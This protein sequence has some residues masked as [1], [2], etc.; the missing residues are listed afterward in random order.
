MII[1]KISSKANV[2]KRVVLYL[3][4]VIELPFIAINRALI[5]E[6]REDNIVWNK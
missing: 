6:F 5:T 3:M 2:L 4:P 1:V